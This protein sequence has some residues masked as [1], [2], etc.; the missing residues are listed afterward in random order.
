[1]QNC[2]DTLALSCFAIV[3]LTWICV[4]VFLYQVCD[5]LLLILIYWN[6]ETFLWIIPH[7]YGWWEWC[8]VQYD[9]R[10]LHWANFCV[11][12]FYAEEVYIAGTYLTT[13]VH[14]IKVINQYNV[15]PFW[16]LLLRTDRVSSTLHIQTSFFIL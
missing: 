13:L 3:L 9:K 2:F 12:S 5:L 14:G 16:K 10:W 11:S 1:M 4:I 8:A 15:C 7:P 6:T